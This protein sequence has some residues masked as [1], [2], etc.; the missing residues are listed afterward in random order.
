[1]LIGTGVILLDQITKYFT[2]Q[3]ELGFQEIII[4]NLLVLT[5]V[6]NT[7]ISFGQFPGNNALWG[8][9]A[10]IVLGLLVYWYDT[11][12]T[13]VSKVGYW[14]IIGGLFGNLLDRV[15]HG[16]VIDMFNV[17][18]FAIFNV[19]DAAISIAVVLLVIEEIRLRNQNS[20]A[21]SNASK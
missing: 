16:A 9:V 20:S 11:F 7:G 1:M 4:P 14:L 8:W 17:P 18:W 5:H 15:F 3:L 6:T 21:S 2:R 10:V 19:A 12:E 13:T